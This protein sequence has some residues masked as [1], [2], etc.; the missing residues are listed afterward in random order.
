MRRRRRRHILVGLVVLV[1]IVAVAY[2]VTRVQSEQ[3][4]RRE[5]LDRALEFAET[6]ADLADQLADMVLRL[7]QIGRPVMAS[8][9]DDLQQGTAAAARDLETVESPPGDLAEADRYLAIAAVRWRDGISRVRLG[10]IGLSEAAMDQEARDLLQQGLT[11]LRVGDTAF[12][13]F[14]E[15]LGEDDLTTVGR[16][17]P[18][19]EFVPGGAESLYEADG[20][21]ERLILA[22]GLTVLENLAVADL[23]LDPAPVGE[24]V[25]LPVVPVSESL[26]AD[27]TVANRGTVR[28]VG[29][30]VILELVTQE[31]TV[32]RFEREVAVLEPGALTTVSFTGL[33]AEPGGLYEILVSLGAEDDNPADDRISFTFIRNTSE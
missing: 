21:A 28:A 27:V 9:L 3:Q 12:V 29:V 24:Q 2:A 32:E 4:Q 30:T 23:R 1:V 31:A 10:L 6:E 17:F 25:G 7:E 22:P 8:T 26:N 11:D 20:L 19:V 15:G 18:A 13:G 33:P 16:E 5:Y 14:L